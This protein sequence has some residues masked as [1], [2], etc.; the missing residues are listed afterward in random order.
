[1]R[2]QNNFY[3]PKGLIEPDQKQEAEQ[4]NIVAPA[5]P[6]GVHIPGGSNIHE[7]NINYSGDRIPTRE[8]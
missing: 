7:Q 2:T 8:R 6:N 5:N 3:K 1:M 4:K